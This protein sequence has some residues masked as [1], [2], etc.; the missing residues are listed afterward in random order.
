MGCSSVEIKRNL[1]GTVAE[2]PCTTLAFEPGERAVVLC[3]IEEPE[4]VVGGRIVLP[5][6]TRSYGFFWTER[7]YIAYHW[8]VGG[9]T[10]LHYLNIGRVASL[11]PEEIVWDDYAV[12]ILRWPDGRVEV[13]DEDEVPAD[14]E[15]ATLAFI[16]AAR[17]RV[18]AEL[19]DVVA[20]VERETDAYEGNYAQSKEA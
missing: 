18:L 12:D 4:P 11:A 1:D 8:L 6:G 15:E 16:A 19:G 14:T 3:E 7:P 2:Y 13:V 9:E 10:F 5:A 20:Q 17:E